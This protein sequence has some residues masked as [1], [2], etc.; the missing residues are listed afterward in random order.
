M[1]GR[2]SN[3]A[4]LRYCLRLLFS[5]CNSGDEVVHMDLHEQ[6]AIP[7]LIGELYTNM[8]TMCIKK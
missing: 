4:Q 6:G 2:G 5:V 7:L 3:L 8:Y 1:G